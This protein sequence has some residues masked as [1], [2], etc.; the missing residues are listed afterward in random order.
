MPRRKFKEPKAG[1][2]ICHQTESEF[3]IA[4]TTVCIF[5]GDFFVEGLPYRTNEL[6]HS[7]LKFGLDLTVKLYDGA[8]AVRYAVDGFDWTHPVTL[9]P[10]TLAYPAVRGKVCWTP[11]LLNAPTV[12]N[13]TEW[14]ACPDASSC[15]CEFRDNAYVCDSDA[16]MWTGPLEAISPGETSAVRHDAP[17]YDADEYHVY[18]GI[19]A[20]LF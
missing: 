18:A 5:D 6:N 4:S 2:N 9:L 13:C 16:L 15:E 20:I 7:S 10:V 14:G 19:E 11:D 17:S 8:W 3:G 1:W 12:T